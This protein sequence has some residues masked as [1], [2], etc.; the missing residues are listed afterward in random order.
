MQLLRLRGDRLAV[1]TVTG[2]FYEFDVNT[3]ELDEKCCLE[4]QSFLLQSEHIPNGCLIGNK[5]SLSLYDSRKG[6]PQQLLSLNDNITCWKL[7]R[8]KII[9]VGKHLWIGSH[10]RM[11]KLHT[12]PEGIQVDSIVEYYSSYLLSSR[13]CQ[14]VLLYESDLNIMGKVQHAQHQLSLFS[15]KNRLVCGHPNGTMDLCIL[16]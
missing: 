2:S 11:E 12:L 7:H 13:S 8:D 4:P 5:S 10:N 16:K 1:K 6:R 9:A 15:L 3:L 14:N